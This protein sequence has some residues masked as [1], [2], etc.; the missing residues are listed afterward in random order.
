MRSWG[1]HRRCPGGQCIVLGAQRR[2]CLLTEAHQAVDEVS[3]VC[4]T[5]LGDIDAPLRIDAAQGEHPANARQLPAV[6]LAH[7]DGARIALA[8][9]AREPQPL[10]A[11]RERQMAMER[12]DPETSGL[13]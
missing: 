4:L 8:Q 1:A 11:Q 7:V 2:R 6:V 12:E 9:R 13:S 5:L 10:E 3:V